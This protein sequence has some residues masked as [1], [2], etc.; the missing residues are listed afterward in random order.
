M[1]LARCVRRSANLASLTLVAAALLAGCKSPYYADRGAVTGGAI[2]TGIGAIVGNQSG[3]AAEGALVG[4]AIGGLTGAVIGDSL[5]EIDARNR[6]LIAQQIGRQPHPGAVPLTDVI[7]MSQSGVSDQL[8][9]THVRTN[10]VAAPLTSQDLI[11]LKQAGVSDAVVL[12]MQTPAPR[13][14]AVPAEVVVVPPHP[15]V[16][17]ESHFH[18]HRVRPWPPRRRFC[19]PPHPHPGWNFGVGYSN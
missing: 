8:I 3:N 12:A 6:A 11:T 14:A 1:Y 10:G 16:I 13:V 18:G 4:A 15:P 5:D 19:P 17:V 9:V 7:T 2:G